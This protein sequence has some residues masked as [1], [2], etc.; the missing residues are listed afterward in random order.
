MKIYRFCFAHKTASMFGFK[1]LKRIADANAVPLYSANNTP[2]NHGG[3]ARAIKRDEDN[4]I[5]FGPE[6]TYKWIPE[7]EAAINDGHEVYDICQI[8][9]PLDIIVS[10]YFSHGWI[11][12][13]CN[14]A[15]TTIRVRRR[16]QN[17][18]I[19][20]FDYAKLE[21]SGETHFA[22]SSVAEKFSPLDE[23]F[24]GEARKVVRY[25][26]FYE[27]YEWWASCVAKILPEKFNA[28]ELLLDERPDYSKAVTLEDGVFF[29]NAL[30]YVEK[31]GIKSGKHIRSA[32][33]GDHKH[34][35]TPTQILYLEKIIFGNS[36]VLR[37]QYAVD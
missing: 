1:I 14:W 35:L 25:E 16:I 6:R 29:E 20:I 2:P 4:I 36:R 5:L 24:R 13:E 3:I 8:R 31:F 17:G 12:P 21:L 7:L 28:R 23:K 34:F 11:H 10:Q 26:D 27:N 30:Q 32:E 37:G 15:D 22:D 33:P 9:H 19:S 18:E